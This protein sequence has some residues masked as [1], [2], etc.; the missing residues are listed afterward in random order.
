MDVR[1]RLSQIPMLRASGFITLVQVH[2]TNTRTGHGR[3]MKKKEI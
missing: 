1:I 3:L 2:V